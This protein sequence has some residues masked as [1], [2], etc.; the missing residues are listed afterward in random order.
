VRT[1][2]EAQVGGLYM[3]KPVENLQ[4]QGTAPSANAYG[5]T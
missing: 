5:D 4:W 3:V 2:E 1:V